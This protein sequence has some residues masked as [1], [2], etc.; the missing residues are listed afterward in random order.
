MKRLKII[1]LSKLAKQGGRCYYC[2]LPIWIVRKESRI[3][4]ERK[5]WQLQCT[6]EH[7][8]ARCDGGTDHPQNIVAACRF[9]NSRRHHGKKPKSSDQHRVHVQRR[10]AKGRWLA[11]LVAVLV[12]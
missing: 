2:E 10:M 5:P 6:A 3:A 7:L 11:P 4:A 9:C 12:S 8:I 1:C